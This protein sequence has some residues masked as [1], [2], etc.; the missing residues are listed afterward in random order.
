MT[1]PE[2]ASKEAWL[3]ITPILIEAIN[4][5]SIWSVAERCC[6]LV[7]EPVMD[8]PSRNTVLAH[9]SARLQNALSDDIDNMA[10]EPKQARDI[11]LKLQDVSPLFTAAAQAAKAATNVSDVQ[12][13]KL[14]W[15]AV[16]SPPE[17]RRIMATGLLLF[18][19]ARQQIAGTEAEVA[20]LT[21]LRTHL[22]SKQEDTSSS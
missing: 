9:V 16:L 19:A 4:K 11:L 8:E 21:D 10:P 12:H 3:V 13:L 17:R 18:A 7:H 14:L 15:E 6:L 20:G 2:C 22:M 5:N 1:A